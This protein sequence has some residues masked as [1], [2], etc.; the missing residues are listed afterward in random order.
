M[1][2]EAI[3]SILSAIGIEDTEDR[4]GK[5]GR[6]VKDI[7][8]VVAD[9][10]SDI[11]SVNL[12]S[13]NRKLKIRDLQSD[14][15][16]ANDKVETKESEIETLKGDSSLT[17]ITKE[18]DVLKVYKEKTL[19]RN[20]LDFINEF[21]LIKDHNDYERL[22]EKLAVPDSE[23]G[24]VDWTK[25]SDEEI[26]KNQEMIQV[27]RSHGLFENIKSDKTFHGETVLKSDKDEG[28]FQ[29]KDFN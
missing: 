18:L 1:Y 21:K 8:S 20:R 15:E 25:A 12:E 5:V 24:E 28:Y 6:A 29:D 19:G 13:K 23:N 22:P 27:A 26:E 9:L 3:E 2:K 17:D 14:L 4:Q 7:E 10:K 16:T 11:E